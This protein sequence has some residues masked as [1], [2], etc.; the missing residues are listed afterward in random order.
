MQEIKGMTIYCD[1][2]DYEIVPGSSNF[3]V[4][5]NHRVIGN[6][7]T[8]MRAEAFVKRRINPVET[9]PQIYQDICRCGNSK[10]GWDYFTAEGIVYERC[11]TCKRPLRMIAIKLL[12]EEMLK[13]FDLEDIFKD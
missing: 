10:I 12:K 6:F 1:A 9:R 11:N 13:D 8:M 3:Q 4:L 2:E 7:P 5:R